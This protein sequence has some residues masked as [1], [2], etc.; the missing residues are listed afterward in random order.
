MGLTA[1]RS[2]PDHRRQGYKPPEY[3]AKIVPRD[4]LQEESGLAESVL[5]PQVVWLHNDNVFTKDANGRTVPK[6]YIYAVDARTGSILK[7]RA[8]FRPLAHHRR[9]P[10]DRSG[11]LRPRRPRRRCWT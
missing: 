7:V 4:F 3:H 8:L 10:T 5:N 11:I 2:A 6:P 1:T 9:G